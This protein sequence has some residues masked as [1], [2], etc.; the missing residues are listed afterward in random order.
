LDPSADCVLCLKGIGGAP[1][2]TDESPAFAVVHL[3]L[4]GQNVRATVLACGK[5]A[6]DNTDL[7]VVC[8]IAV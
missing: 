2:E 5:R 1:Y 8:D 4:V 6:K 3:E 7:S